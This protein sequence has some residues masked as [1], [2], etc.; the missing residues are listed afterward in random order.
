[1][2]WFRKIKQ[3]YKERIRNLKGIQGYSTEYSVSARLGK[4]YCHV[5]H[6]LLTIKR[7]KRVVNSES[8]EAKGFDFSSG[9]GRMIGNISFSWD[10]Y[11]CAKCDFEISVREQRQYERGFKLEA[12]LNA[13]DSFGGNTGKF[14]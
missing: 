7:N 12:F 11:H 10:V 4:H 3:K 2:T 8:E 5:C 14:I 6:E 1:M 9:E 13:S